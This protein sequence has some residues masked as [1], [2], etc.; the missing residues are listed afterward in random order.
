[1]R[2]AAARNAKELSQAELAEKVGKRQ[3][4]IADYEGGK[5]EPS[6]AM[7]REIAKNTGTTPGW[8][9]FGEEDRGNSLFDAAVE[10]DKQN[11]LFAWAFHQ[12]ARLLSDEG[13]DGDFP[14]TLR[15]TQKFLRVPDKGAEEAQAKEAVL[16]AIEVDRAEFR[17]ALDQIRK[18]RL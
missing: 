8:L 16:R 18:N 7:Y 2:I 4:T 3:Q 9:I 15:L 14:Y 10:A 13:L 1:M 6:L 12:T 5:P 11:R 17:K